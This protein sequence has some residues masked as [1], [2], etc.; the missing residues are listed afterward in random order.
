M[1]LGQEEKVA[2]ET[3]EATPELVVVGSGNLGAVWF[4]RR[5][6]RL[7]LE[8]FAAEYPGLIPGLAEHPGVSFVVLMTEQRGAVAIGPGGV[9]YLD[10]GL[11]DGVDPLERF[12]EQALPDFQ[13]V[14]HFPNA[15]DIYLNSMWNEERAEVA[16]FEGLVGCHG[17]L[18]GWQDSAL[19]VYPSEWTVAEQI[20][21][22]D[23]LHNQLV[24]WL[25]DLGHRSNLPKSKAGSPDFTEETLRS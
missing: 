22:A 18:G 16:A 23:Q 11:V 4:A 3:T 8:N 9:H 6:G 25:E 24:R 13:R 12:G 21:G 17:G 14:A 7:T 15:P 1:A 5:P 20:T 19:L 2:S 10:E